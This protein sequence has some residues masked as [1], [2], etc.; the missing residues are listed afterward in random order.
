M[1]IIIYVICSTL[2]AGVCAAAQDYDRES[3][4][5]I[6]GRDAATGELGIGVQS[7]T[8]ATG[9]RSRG[10]KGGVAVI[11][12]QAASNPMYG[13]L[14][15]TL[16][17]AGMTPQQA[18]DMMLRGDAG[19]DS[20]Q[21]SILDIRGRTAAWTSPTITDWKG[22]KCGVDYCAQG[23]TLLGPQVVEAMANS[24]ESSTGPL[25]ERLLA[26]LDAAQAAGGEKRGM[27]SASLLILKPL[28]IQGFGDRELDLRVD[29]HKT[30]L[31]ELRRVLNAFRSRELIS[32]ATARLNQGDLQGAMS[33]ALA[34]REK[35]SDNDTAWVA[36][37]D[38]DL[39]LGKKTEALQALRMA[40]A[41]NAANK[42][43]LKNDSRFKSLYEDPEFV[44]IVQ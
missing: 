23:N 28:S 33:R 17:E 19:K 37:A 15:V 38:I 2:L 13:T 11:A 18:L 40:V 1:R 44:K 36:I 10:G 43:Q 34:A 9:S 25:A 22:H 30:P 35:F 4:Y 26:A 32:E 42:R 27:E 20:R 29:E 16:L 41:I 24:F 31:V 14:G 7:K 12:H 8:V 3:T 39:R 5:S 6:I 21:V